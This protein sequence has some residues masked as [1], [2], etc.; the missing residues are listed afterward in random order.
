MKITK[1]KAQCLKC[2]DIIESTYT[3]DFRKCSCGALAVDGGLDYIRRTFSDPGI[4]KELSECDN[5]N[6]VI[7]EGDST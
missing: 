3:H 6:F 2:G 4:C 7:K 5:K 1:K